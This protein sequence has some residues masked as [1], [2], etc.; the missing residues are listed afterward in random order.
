MTDKLIDVAVH[1]RATTITLRSEHNRN[2]LT[3]A[4]RSALRDAL[5]QAHRESSVIVL[6]HTGKVFCAGMDLRE[7]G[8]LKAGLGELSELLELVAHGPVPVIVKL[9][10]PAYAGGVGLV[11]AADIAVSV[12]SATF[13]FT[14]VRLGVV[15]AMISA[16]VLPKLL[17]RHARELL[18]TGRKFSAQHAEFVGLLTRSVPST[19]L[20]AV[21]DEYVAELLTGEPKAL[22]ATKKLIDDTA[23]A[24]LSADELV[25]L[26]ARYFLSSEGQEGMRAFAEKRAPRWVEG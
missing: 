13:A 23:N 17:P 4:M 11:A 19:E 7:P 1:G 20:D 3:A 12:D 6:T 18:L 5:T 9:N 15:P 26:S 16:V 2:A 22:A 21:V 24:P 25:E 10:G 8:D 14:E